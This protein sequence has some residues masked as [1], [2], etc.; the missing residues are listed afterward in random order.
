MTNNFDRY[1]QGKK[2][3]GGRI[4]RKTTR[5]GWFLLVALIVLNAAAWSYAVPGY[6]KMVAVGVETTVAPRRLATTSHSKKNKP[7]QPGFILTRRDSN[8]MAFAFLDVGQGDAIFF[9]TPY[10][11]NVLVDSG[12]G[13]NPDFKFA[14][15]VK[16]GKRLILPFFRR[17]KIRKL[18]Y[19]IITHPHSDHIGSA[20]D[21]I[22]NMTIDEVWAAGYSHPSRSKKDMLNAI[23]YK[24]SRSDLEFKIPQAKGGTLKEGQPLALGPGVKGWL[25]RTAP[26]AGNTNLSSLVLLIYYGE[27]GV[28]LTGDT[29]KSGERQLV[30]K[31]GDQLNVE[32]LKV[33]HHGSRTSSIPPFIN[34]VK[35]QHSVIMVGQYN[36]FGHPT[37]EVLSRL[38]QAGSRIH[39][40][41]RDG[42]IFMFLDGH[43]ISVETKPA[44]SAVN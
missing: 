9:Q 27:T 22:K 42:T 40:T 44:V 30:R 33:G 20:G 34:V 2:E 14:R 24:K 25:I 5:T 15:P 7:L 4:D 31:W 1:R 21:I 3:H 35:P 37:D 6:R 28:L 10:G 39:R 41:D 17:N 11:K 29:E 26:D 8:E 12:E 43:S 18:D 16:A 23:E 36:S 13:S 32:V 38:K 19:F